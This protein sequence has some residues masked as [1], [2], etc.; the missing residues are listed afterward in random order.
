MRKSGLF[1]IFNPI[2]M[3]SHLSPLLAST[4]EAIDPHSQDV[5]E[6]EERLRF[7]RLVL[8]KVDGLSS[9]LAGDKTDE[10]QAL[11]FDPQHTKKPHASLIAPTACVVAYGA[12]DNVT[13]E[14]RVK[15]IPLAGSSQMVAPRY[16]PARL[17]PP[18]VKLGFTCSNVEGEIELQA[19]DVTEVNVTA[20]TTCGRR[21]DTTVSAMDPR[22]VKMLFKRSNRT[23]S[24]PPLTPGDIATPIAL[25]AA[26]FLQSDVRGHVISAVCAPIG[27]S[28]PLAFESI[29][30]DTQTL[31]PKA[32]SIVMRAVVHPSSITCGAALH[33]MLPLDQRCA[34]HAKLKASVCEFKLRMCGRL[35]PKRD[36]GTFGECTLHARATITSSNT[37][38]MCTHGASVSFGCS[39]FRGKKRKS[40]MFI[41]DL[42]VGREA[43]R[44]LTC[45]LFHSANFVRRAEPILSSNERIQTLT[46]RSTLA[47]DAA[48]GLVNTDGAESDPFNLTYLDG[49][50][51]EL[52]IAGDVSQ[53][54]RGKTR[55]ITLAREGTSGKPE[56]LSGSEGQLTKTH[57][58][59]FPRGYWLK[60]F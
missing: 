57:L 10:I 22:I 58:G 35:L 1:Y 15:L 39:H 48:L 8:E 41:P 26:H 18:I 21:V 29:R 49:L 36:D 9:A 13:D 43:K 7:A 54:V 46:D 24:V 25:R 44:R 2:E 4:L 11:L 17:P 45:L 30:L 27:S 42:L 56:V 12:I 52:L 34:K 50:A 14:T 3:A 38:G 6:G 53:Y 20:A 5:D 19:R 23:P 33:K 16:T 51:A 60:R 37:P 32:P 47:L 40:C 28:R 59:L 55:E 31:E